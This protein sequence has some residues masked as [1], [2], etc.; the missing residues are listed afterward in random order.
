MYFTSRSVPLHAPVTMLALKPFA[1]HPDCLCYRSHLL[2]LGSLPLC[3]GCTCMVLGMVVASVVLCLA[4]VFELEAFNRLTVAQCTV[5]GVALYLPTLGQPFWQWRP[6][7]IVSRFLLGGGVVLLFFGG[8]VLLPETVTGLAFRML[9]V[10]VF[11]ATLH[12]SL[13]L[14][15][16]CSASPARNCRHGGFPFCQ[17]RDQMIDF[18]SESQHRHCKAQAPSLNKVLHDLSML[19]STLEVHGRPKRKE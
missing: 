5:S 10:I 8:I 12:L 18:I 15:Q 2:R 11:C 17:S 3:L 13:R 4:A 14:R 7:K 19:D 16:Q 1:H 9:F 6:F